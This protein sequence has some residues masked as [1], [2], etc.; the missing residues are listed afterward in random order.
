MAAETCPPAL[1]EASG[2][3]AQQIETSCDAS[4]DRETSR[5][6]RTVRPDEWI[7]VHLLAF[8]ERLQSDEK[9]LNIFSS[10][11]AAL[12]RDPHAYPVLASKRIDQRMKII[13][14]VVID[15]REP[16]AC[17]ALATMRGTRDP[18]GRRG[19]DKRTGRS[20][21]SGPVDRR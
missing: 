2:S 12:I 13:A 18:Q 16:W 8:V 1:S 5:S 21:V 11:L 4:R 20:Y 10:P 19:R 14:L 7:A 15:Q 17:S 3:N 6:I 9:D